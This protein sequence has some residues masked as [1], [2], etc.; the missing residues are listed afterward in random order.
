MIP[1]A[2]AFLPLLGAAAP[3]QPA[4]PAG[5]ELVPY[6]LNAGENVAQLEPTVGPAGEPAVR[7]RCA[8]FRGGAVELAWR[9]PLPLRAGAA[10]ELSLACRHVRVRG[11][12]VE[13]LLRDGQTGAALGSA[14]RVR[15][16]LRWRSF[17]RRFVCPR[18]VRE[19]SVVLRFFSGGTLYVAQPQ[20]AEVW[21]WLGPPLAPC[22]H[23]NRVFNSSFELGLCGWATLEAESFL[24]ALSGRALRGERCLRLCLEREKL[25]RLFFDWPAP[26]SR[27]LARISAVAL[28]PS[29]LDRGK[30]MTLSAYLR[31]EPPGVVALLGLL[32][33]GQSEPRWAEAS[34][35]QAWGRYC[36]TFVPSASRGWVAVGLDLDK[37]QLKE[38]TLWVDAVQLEPRS[39]AT[40][41]R[42]AHNIEV[43]II[44][45]GEMFAA[46]GDRAKL[47]ICAANAGREAAQAA[48]KLSCFDHCGRRVLWRWF[49]V[50]LRPGERAELPVAVELKHSGVY[51]VSLRV[52][53]ER[54]ERERRMRLF[55]APRAKLSPLAP[56]LGLD[57]LPASGALAQAVKKLGI[58]WVLD[59]SASWDAAS[60]KEGSVNF[61][62]ADELLSFAAREG[63][64][65]VVL[66]AAPCARWASAGPAAAESLSTASGGSALCWY[67][68]RKALDFEEFLQELARFA[69]KRAAAWQL[70]YDAEQNAP[71]GQLSADDFAWLALAARR[72]LCQ[73]TRR[74]LAL[75]LPRDLL[76]GS[77]ATRAADI[78]VVFPQLRTGEEA[79]EELRLLA[80]LRGRELW[81]EGIARAAEDELAAAAAVA[82]AMVVLTWAG[83]SRVFFAALPEAATPHGE[84]M[85]NPFF[86]YGPRPR[87]AAVALLVALDMMGGD[88]RPQLVRGDSRLCAFRWRRGKEEIFALWAWEP[89]FFEDLALPKAGVKF[90]DMLGA[91]SERPTQLDDQPVYI[92]CDT[93]RAEAVAAA[94]G[95]REA[96]R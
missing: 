96:E 36:A 28:E 50:R 90:F 93:L 62:P 31:S 88:A 47:N 65:T 20:V 35:S 82:R 27:A 30:P 92:V 2:L 52:R 58:N 72:C 75:S 32:S 16:G 71:Q 70:F 57:H 74:P 66:L 60:G 23:K 17:A 24:G 55:C 79:A 40:S 73:T 46:P 80:A 85:S 18:E 22:R 11:P 13:I 77:C 48:I 68:P 4:A 67:P 59:R 15:P 87:A 95:A 1:T 64:S 54:C 19:V 91:P 49:P 94:L 33:E 89:L 63:L 81:A 26:E 44:S 29:A 39:K 53:G 61:A 69:G 14:W 10:Y 43:G 34:V 42:P 51:A 8:E 83:A 6:T 5:A 21:P 38:A 12:E 9:L 86:A 56:R 25:P 76:L 84:T 78:A 37:S 3:Q 45:E 7:V 41:Y